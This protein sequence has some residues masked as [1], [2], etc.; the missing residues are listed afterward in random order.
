MVDANDI[1]K[2]LYAGYGIDSGILLGIPSDRRP[3][4]E[5]LIDFTILHMS[6]KRSSSGDGEEFT[7]N[8]CRLRATQNPS[9][10]HKC[11]TSMHIGPTGFPGSKR[12]PR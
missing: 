4:M 9:I 12:Q 11:R 1:L 6:D 7:R 3:S 5:A 10:L 2:N 8:R